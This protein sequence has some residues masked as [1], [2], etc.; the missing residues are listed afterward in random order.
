[1][2]WSEVE[3]LSC[4]I[5]VMCGQHNSVDEV[6]D[7]DG[8]KGIVPVSR[9]QEQALFEVLERQRDP[10]PAP[11]TID[12][13]RANH[14]D[15][16]F[17]LGPCRND[18]VLGCDLGVA[19]DV[20]TAMD[21]IRFRHRLW[22]VKAVDTARRDVDQSPYALRHCCTDQV[23]RA[24]RVDPPSTLVAN[25]VRNGGGGVNHAIRATEVPLPR[26]AYRDI[27][28]DDASLGR[29]A[30]IETDH[31][32]AGPSIVVD[33][34]APNEARSSRNRDPFAFGSAHP[35]PILSLFLNIVSVY[36]I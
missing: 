20:A 5:F 33:Q 1:M 26:P 36:D 12:I 19:I 27:G 29:G 31:L 15:F 2:T 28:R 9:K 11:R 10:H 24:K 7:V 3:N 13:R 30:K 21:R 34:R 35:I 16:K 8:Q 6:I 17:A 18:S 23:A 14:D 4:T 22:R 25:R 32:Y